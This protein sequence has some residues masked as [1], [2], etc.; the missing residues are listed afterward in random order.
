MNT[1]N[2]KKLWLLLP[3]TKLYRRT[4]NTRTNCTMW[5][6]LQHG[7]WITTDEIIEDM[8]NHK[9]TII[10][11]DWTTVYSWFRN[12][13]GEDENANLSY[14]GIIE[15]MQSVR[16]KLTNIFYYRSWVTGIIPDYITRILLLIVLFAIFKK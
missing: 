14:E 13:E 16:S 8:Q 12:N 9:I 15:T 7:S 2:T 6:W 3:T 11:P 10:A 1:N 4:K 5:T